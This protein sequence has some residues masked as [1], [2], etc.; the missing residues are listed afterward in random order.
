MFR[1]DRH[2]G[3]LDEVREEAEQHQDDFGPIRCPEWM[4][5]EA[6][7]C[8]KEMIKPARWLDNS[9]KT[10]AVAYCEL[11][12]EFV[13]DP[14]KFSPAKHNQMRAYAGELGLTDFRNRTSVKRKKKDEF[15]DD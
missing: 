15:F 1:A 11:W 9:R 14:T 10:A 7:R 4:I 3:D 2:G 8:W 6:L 5:G 13:G 12:A